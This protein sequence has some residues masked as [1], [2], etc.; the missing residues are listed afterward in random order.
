MNF[1]TPFYLWLLPLVSIPLIIYLFNRNKN[2]RI[3]FSS[4]FL[5]NKIKDTTV[6][7]INLINILLLIIRTLI[8]LFFILMLSRP[9]YSSI[10]DGDIS[11]DSI[12][13]IAVDNSFT[14]TNLLENKVKK[15]IHDILKEFNDDT[16]FK[17]VALDN[18][19][20]IY[21]GINSKEK[22]L[23]INNTFSKTNLSSINTIIDDSEKYLNKYLFILSDGQE[24]VFNQKF[25]DKI[26]KKWFVNYIKINDDKNNG[27][28]LSVKSID[29][30]I[31]I[32]E[33]FSITA[34]IRNNGNYKLSN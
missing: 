29:K 12:V 33:N 3:L 2:I 14:M 30:Y 28:I 5:L 20:I 10:N 1:I 23:V 31:T 25:N 7:K 11:T 9:T 4:L 21:E 6:K 27:G 22:K 32:N 18:K 13:V 24:N 16:Y 17:I 19:Q 34:I 26:K 8:I 15:L